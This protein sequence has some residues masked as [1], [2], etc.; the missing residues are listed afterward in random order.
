MH[1]YP[2][3]ATRIC[4]RPVDV[5][6]NAIEII[7]R[8]IPETTRVN[9]ISRFTDLSV[10]KWW[11]TRKNHKIPMIQSKIFFQNQQLTI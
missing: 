8:K 3:I 9:A 6:S 7:Q 2:P 5:T 10:I 4:F 1:K 11:K